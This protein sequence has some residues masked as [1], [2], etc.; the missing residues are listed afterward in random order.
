MNVSVK[1]SILNSNLEENF[2]TY[3]FGKS[4]L[5]YRRLKSDCWISRHLLCEKKFKLF[6]MW[7]CFNTSRK[8]KYI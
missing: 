2:S 1:I 4:F 8:V 7:G 5:Y 3:V 6:P